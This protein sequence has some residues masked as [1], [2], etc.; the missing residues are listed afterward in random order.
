MFY[1]T[2]S[3]RQQLLQDMLSSVAVWTLC[4][5]AAAV[6][7]FIFYFLFCSA[8]LTQFSPSGI[9]EHHLLSLSA[10]LHLTDA[11]N[12]QEFV[13]MT[14]ETGD[15]HGGKS[16]LFLYTSE[17]RLLLRDGDQISFKVFV[18]VGEAFRNKLLSESVK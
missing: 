15:R 12:V 14:A 2:G 17:I 10:P 8:V 13:L 3:S 5:S 9:N 18:D 16:I 7:L 1:Q 4:I 6:V 11:T